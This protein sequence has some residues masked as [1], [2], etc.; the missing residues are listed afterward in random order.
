[1]DDP[2]NP[3]GAEH[4]WQWLARA[5]N[6]LPANRLNAKAIICFLRAAGYRLNLRRAQPKP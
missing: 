6:S 4:G 5:L 3:H 2:L 1:V